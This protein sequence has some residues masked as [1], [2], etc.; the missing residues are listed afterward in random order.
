MK[1]FVVYILQPYANFFCVMAVFASR[2]GAEAFVEAEGDSEY[3]IEE[4]EVKP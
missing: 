1:V 4:F 2:T 3:H